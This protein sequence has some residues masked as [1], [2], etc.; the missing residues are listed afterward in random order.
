VPREST[1]KYS[2]ESDTRIALRSRL[3]LGPATVAELIVCTGRSKHHV[4]H[5]LGE[6]RDAKTLR[7][8][9][10]P[11]ANARRDPAL[12]IFWLERRP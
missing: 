12:K 8:A 9:A 3:L 6:L 7:E 11:G 1:A 10:I 4:A 5:L 2:R